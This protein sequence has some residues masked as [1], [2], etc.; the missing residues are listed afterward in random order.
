MK[1][2]FKIESQDIW[3][4]QKNK[5]QI[6]ND[7]KKEKK[8]EI[9]RY[10][11]YII[12]FISLIIWFEKS[13][14]VDYSLAKWGIAFVELIIVLFAFVP[15]VVQLLYVLICWIQRKHLLKKSF[16]GN[17]STIIVDENGITTSP[18]N[19]KSKSLRWQDIVQV[20]EDDFRYFLYLTDKTFIIVK[21]EPHNLTKEEQVKFNEKIKKNLNNFIRSKPFINKPLF[22]I[23]IVLVV[24]LLIMLLTSLTPSQKETTGPVYE[25]E[26]D[27][28]G[29]FEYVGE[30]I[31]ESIIKDNLTV[32]EID[33][34]RRNMHKIFEELDSAT[35]VRIPLSNLV[36][37]A[38]KQ[39]LEKIH[40]PTKETNRIFSGESEHFF[41]DNFEVEVI[42][43]KIKYHESELFI[44]DNSGISVDA[45]DEF[46]VEISTIFH[47]RHEKRI[48]TFVYSED[49][50]D[51]I[52]IE[53]I[54]V[55]GTE[56]LLFIN[57]ETG[58]TIIEPTAFE[59]INK[60][61]LIIQWKEKSKEQLYEERLLLIE[62]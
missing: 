39:Y 18:E 60:I 42:F 53:Q 20:G 28:Y 56:Y 8:K 36:N 26:Q 4:A 7:D 37:E 61:E 38:E 21:K 62:K 44:K 30:D 41:I 31:S 25:L 52:D 59:D 12:I 17:E 32:E 2:K 40:V 47:E 45:L 50:A 1:A 51:Y 49:I 35:H 15:L 58:F 14:K 9:I 29:L 13:Q 22:S 5:W 33:N 46:T 57:E 23:R 10:V 16:F 6:S 11:I 43:D 19:K 48:H 54:I 3:A 27:V 24:V 34:V 55:G